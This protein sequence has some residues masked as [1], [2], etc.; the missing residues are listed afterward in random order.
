MISVREYKKALD[1]ALLPPARRREAEAWVAD[2]EAFARKQ[3]AMTRTFAADKLKAALAN[4]VNASLLAAAVVD[5]MRAGKFTP[6]AAMQQLREL[7]TWVA[8][9]TAT[10]PEVQDELAAA[11][12]A[13]PL[14]TFDDFIQRFPAFEARTP[15]PPLLF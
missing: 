13:D 14:A 11:N 12:A 5:G 2:R 10:L 1:E 9:E 4:A 15:A 6:A 3:I 7:D 8:S